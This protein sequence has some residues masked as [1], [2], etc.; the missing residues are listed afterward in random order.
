MFSYTFT[1]LTYYAEQLQI[2]IKANS[3][4]A[5]KYSYL[6]TFGTSITIVFAQELLTQEETDLTTIVNNHTGATS[7][8]QLAA[9]LDNQVFPFIKNLINQ[10]AAENISMGITQAGKTGDVLG[11]FEKQYTVSG[12]NKPVSL[13]AAFDTGSL[14]VARQILQ[15]VRDNPIEFAGLS[16]FITDSRLLAMKNSIETFLG[17]PL[18]T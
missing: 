13:K 11:L 4:L 5:N 16:P 10:F 17:I 3:A 18:S 12:I 9:Y 6:S 8:Q 14:Y 1:K 2:E 15:H 7:A